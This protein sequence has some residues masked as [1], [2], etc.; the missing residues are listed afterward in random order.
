[1]SW[2]N[3]AS[4]PFLLLTPEAALSLSAILLSNTRA[5]D[6]ALN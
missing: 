2:N 6:S 5:E 3:P 4:V 1:L